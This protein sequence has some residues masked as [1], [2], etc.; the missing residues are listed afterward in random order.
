MRFFR[1]QETLNEKLMREAGLLPE[2]QVEPDAAPVAPPPATTVQAPAGVTGHPRFREADAFLTVDA[3]ELGGD[4]VQFVALPD[5]SLLV[6]AGDDDDSPLDPVASAVE[7]E[8][9][10][11][12]RA[13]AARQSASLWAVEVRRIEVVALP[14]APDGDTIDVARTDEGT[15]TEVDG[16][17]IFGSVPELVRLGEERGRD[18]SV[19][20]ERLD[21]DL[22]EIRA[23]AL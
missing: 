3:P 10:P 8:V 13:R 12:Y 9:R 7:G 14:E 11:P 15:R 18:F 20:A 5:G 1:R 4:A 17:R 23:T 2:Q 16:Q 6:E 21:G 19:H 22:W